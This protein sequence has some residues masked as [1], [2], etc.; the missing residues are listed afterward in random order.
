MAK[1]IKEILEKSSLKMI[2]LPFCIILNVLFVTDRPG[3]KAK[4]KK[5]INAK[6]ETL[7]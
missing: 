7:T 3:T 1:L 6:I 4:N 5:I 2:S